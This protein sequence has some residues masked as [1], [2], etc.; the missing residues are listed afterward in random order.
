MLLKLLYV[1]Y[2][3]LL[4]EFGKLVFSTNLKFARISGQVFKLF[5]HFS[6]IDSFG[7]IWLGDRLKIFKWILE[8]LSAS[9]ILF[10]FSYYTLMIFL[11]K[12]RVIFLSMLMIV[13]VTPNVIC[14]NSL[15]WLPIF[16]LNLEIMHKSINRLL[17]C[18][19]GKIC[20]IWSLKVHSQVWDDFWQL[21]D[22]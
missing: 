9:F 3:R 17:I 11:V 20:F 5:L 10:F 16:N 21:K 18:I 2:Q 14:D 4:T 1:I 15:G 12:L 19:A 7:E 22:L 13:L 6:A 8:L